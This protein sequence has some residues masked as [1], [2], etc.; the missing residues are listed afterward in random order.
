[1]TNIENPTLLRNLTDDEFL[2]LIE[3]ND[4][5]VGPLMDELRFRINKAAITPREIPDLLLYPS[6]H[7]CNE[8]ECDV[9]NGEKP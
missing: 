5:L 8:E 2:K 4:T 1:M 3:N 9:C 6:E 7:G